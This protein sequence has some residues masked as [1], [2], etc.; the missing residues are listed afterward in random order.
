MP[1]SQVVVVPVP[2]PVKP[3]LQAVH[4]SMEPRSTPSR[5]ARRSGYAADRSHALISAISANEDAARFQSSAIRA[6]FH[7]LFEFRGLNLQRVSFIERLKSAVIDFQMQ[8]YCF[9]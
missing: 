5:V 2:Q 4:P 6:A 9:F 3:R 8:R 7:H 1:L